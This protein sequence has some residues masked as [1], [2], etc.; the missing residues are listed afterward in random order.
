MWC[1]CQQ[2]QHQ[3]CCQRSLHRTP[4]W[5]MLAV[6]ANCA[7]LQ[8]LSANGWSSFFCLECARRAAELRQFSEAGGDIKSGRGR[9]VRQLYVWARADHRLHTAGQSSACKHQVYRTTR[10]HAEKRLMTKPKEVAN[11]V[12]KPRRPSLCIK[13][14]AGKLRRWSAPPFSSSLMACLRSN[15]T[16]LV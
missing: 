2:R 11:G 6:C 7:R 1:Q 10:S 8:A 9:A 15:V 14:V 3:T 16:L 12:L 5:L 13:S 4:L